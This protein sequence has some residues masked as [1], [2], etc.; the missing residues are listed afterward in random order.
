MNNPLRRFSYSRFLLLT[1][2]SG[3]FCWCFLKRVGQSGVIKDLR[4]RI[5]DTA[6]DAA[7]GTGLFVLTIVAAAIGR[8]ARA[9]Q[10]RQRSVGNA[11]DLTEGDFVGWSSKAITTALAASGI[12]QTPAFEIKQDEFQEFL[13]DFPRAWS[14]P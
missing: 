12:E 4:G 10:W 1:F 3:L 14:W 7:N 13:R 8:D 11:N 2:F 6:H 9:S 5:P